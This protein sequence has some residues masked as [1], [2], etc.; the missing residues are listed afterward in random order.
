[1][2][3]LFRATKHNKLNIEAWLRWAQSIYSGVNSIGSGLDELQ[4]NKKSEIK[5]QLLFGV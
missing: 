2:K 3:K 5:L 1:V 4:G